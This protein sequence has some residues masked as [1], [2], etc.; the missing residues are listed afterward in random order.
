MIEHSTGRDLRFS[1]GRW[2]ATMKTI[3]EQPEDEVPEQQAG[4]QQA[5]T[6]RTAAISGLIL[7]SLPTRR[8]GAL[9][10]AP[11][12]LL[13]IGRWLH[14]NELSDDGFRKVTF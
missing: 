12:G 11:G 2:R 6:P 1:S 4:T 8:P 14:Q 5:V 10:L 7:C 3:F 9:D 13:R